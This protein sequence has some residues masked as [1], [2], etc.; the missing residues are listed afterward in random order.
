MPFQGRSVCEER[1]RFVDLALAGERTISE[2]CEE[3]GIS[4]QC[5]HTW[6]KRYREGGATA[7]IGGRSRRPH[8]SPARTADD[9]ELAIL[10]L[11]ANKPDWGAPKLHRLFLRAHPDRKI[12]VSTVH[13]ILV[14][15]DLIHKSDSHRHATKK[16]ER[17]FPNQL[18]QMDFKGPK[19]FKTRTG[20]LS[21]LDDHSR[22]IL[23]LEHLENGKTEAVK[24][25]LR[26]TFE[27]NGL[28]EAM[29][30][31]HG[32]P[33]W[34]ASSY[35]G[36]TEFSVWL[37][38]QG[39]RILLSGHRHPQTQGKVE[40]MHGAMHHTIVR[41][42]ADADQQS[43][44][45]EFRNEYNQIRP[46][47]ALG[48]ATPASRWQPSTRQFVAEP[49]PWDYPPEQQVLTVDNYGRIKWQTRSL[50]VSQA[51]RGERVGVRTIGHRSIIYFCNTP[52]GEADP[53]SAAVSPLAVDP[54]RS[55]R[56]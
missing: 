40:R 46:H 15:H 27:N 23:A 50:E 16:F 52:I 4:R 36:W 32:T 3:F 51:L 17:E 11:R 30:M 54:F 44:L 19:G 39:V 34:N 24:G 47:E 13:R 49:K 42:R 25:C 5:G 6:L 26:R 45:D 21:V 10:R 9:I 29:L 1:L 20:P 22:Y 43:W 55:L 28:P 37:M 12:S 18:W 48:M 7:V 8:N 41:R 2:L 33:W 53:S 38:R 56:D 14:R 31:D 35:W